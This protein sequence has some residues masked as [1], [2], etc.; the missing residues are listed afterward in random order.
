VEA[1]VS[2]Q[3]LQPGQVCDRP[4]INGLLPYCLEGR[5]FRDSIWI[6]TQA[7]LVDNLFQV[8]ERLVLITTQRVSPRQIIMNVSQTLFEIEESAR[9]LANRRFV[10]VAKEM[11]QDF[12]TARVFL[13]PQNFSIVPLLFYIL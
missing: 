6:N 2:P 1:R 12:N 4:A 3:L 10:Q 7:A 11:I 13:F 5:F 8:T 9:Q